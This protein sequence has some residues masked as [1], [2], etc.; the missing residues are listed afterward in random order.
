MVI[1]S[2]ILEV[3]VVTSI[4]FFAKRIFDDFGE[5]G[6]VVAFA[7]NCADPEKESKL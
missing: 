4:F 6:K 7:R 1:F 3:V 2:F 5:S